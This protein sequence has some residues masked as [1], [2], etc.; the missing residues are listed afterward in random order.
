M[1]SLLTRAMAFVVASGLSRRQIIDTST[2]GQQATCT[3][4]VRLCDGADQAAQDKNPAQNKRFS[5]M[6]NNAFCAK[7]KTPSL[8]KKVKTCVSLEKST[9]Q[10]RYAHLF[11]WTNDDEHPSNTSRR[12]S[13]LK[14]HFCWMHPKKPSACSCIC[15]EGKRQSN[16]RGR[17]TREYI[18]NAV[19]HDRQTG[20]VPWVES[21]LNQ[22]RGAKQNTH[23]LRRNAA[24][25]DV[26]KMPP[27]M[28]PRIHTPVEKCQSREQFVRRHP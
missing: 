7:D 17:A 19:L 9:L 14:P 24:Q 27:T 5:L 1:A 10:H 15:C 22:V 28:K 26:P 2:I 4:R 3:T 20:T 11:S 25:S 6:W 16:R 12:S 8:K 13:S 23:W 21:M 18:Q